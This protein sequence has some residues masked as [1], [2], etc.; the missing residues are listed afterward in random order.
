[1]AGTRLRVLSAPKA[2]T[3]A[4]RAGTPQ[5]TKMKGYLFNFE[6]QGEPELLRLGYYGGFGRLNSQGFGC[7]EII[8]LIQSISSPKAD[9]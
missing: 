7:T 5:E 4:L 2:K 8:R 6:L 3:I 9:V 1:M